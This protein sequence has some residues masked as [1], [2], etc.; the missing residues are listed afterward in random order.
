[1]SL[2]VF[3]MIIA[4]NGCSGDDSE[5]S[6]CAKIDNLLFRSVDFK[7]PRFNGRCSSA[8]YCTVRFLLKSLLVA[9]LQTHKIMTIVFDSFGA[10]CICSLCA[11]H[12]AAA[13]CRF[14]HTFAH[15]DCQILI[16]LRFCRF[17][18]HSIPNSFLLSIDCS[19]QLNGSWLFISVCH[20]TAR[21]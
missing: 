1:M 14:V 9:N 12:S 18:P 8:C 4:S 19:N 7:V 17:L 16:H 15:C 3:T 6:I 21:P 13:Q 20:I 10:V 5:Q 2:R 11:V